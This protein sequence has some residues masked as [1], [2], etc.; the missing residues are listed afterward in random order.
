[1]TPSHRL[2][3]HQMARATDES[4]ALDL[5]ALLGMVEAAYVEADR[6]RQRTDRAT[7]LMCREMEQLNAELEHRA[8]HDA[9][10]GLPNRRLFLQRLK[11]ATAQAGLAEGVALLSIDL[12]RFKRVNDTLG[13]D[14]GDRLLNQAVERMGHQVRA[15]DTLARPGGDEFGLILTRLATAAQAEDVAQRLIET[16]C[17][18]FE[19]DGQ[20]V[21]VGA[22]VGIAVALGGELADPALL[23]RRADVA[24]YAAK[25]A[26]RGAWRL[27]DA[28]MREH[29]ARR[30]QAAG[31]LLLALEPS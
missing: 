19:L 3:A 30:R 11:D 29:A 21:R 26:G 18:P 12:D 5:D 10:T 13:H 22:S 23:Q 15:G 2:L 1:L 28:S 25:A 20:I 7:S 9:L 17:Q 16:L 31:E 24:L 27:F 6:D 8:Y 14:A 4:G